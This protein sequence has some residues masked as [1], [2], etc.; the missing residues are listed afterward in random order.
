MDDRESMMTECKRQK[1]IRNWIRI[2]FHVHKAKPFSKDD[3]RRD[4]AVVLQ[5]YWKSYTPQS[6]LVMANEVNAM[7]E[8][9]F[10][11]CLNS[12]ELVRCGED[13]FILE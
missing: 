2:G 7:I 4:M 11:E 1:W 5:S 13:H 3:I 9:V 12:H 6:R 10:E 8:T